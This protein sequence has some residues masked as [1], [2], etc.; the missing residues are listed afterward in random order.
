MAPSEPASRPPLR[1]LGTVFTLFVATQTLA[2][3]PAGRIRDRD[4]LR[5]VL[6][7]AAVLLAVGS[8]G[9]GLAGLAVLSLRPVSVGPQADAGGD[10]A[11]D[12]R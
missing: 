6:P 10:R 3:F 5:N 9:I 2:Q 12:S 4:S 1:R 7:V 11:V 8:A